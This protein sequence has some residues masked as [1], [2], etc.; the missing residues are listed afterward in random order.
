MRSLKINLGR[1]KM[2]Y[3][4]IKI[5][6]ILA[7]CN[8]FILLAMAVYLTFTYTG[9]IILIILWGLYILSLGL[10]E[11]NYNDY[12]TFNTVQEMMAMLPENKEE[13]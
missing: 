13:D 1:A 11:I 9:S 12:V 7:L 8:S 3:T 6:L 10:L 5:S 2:D 4:R